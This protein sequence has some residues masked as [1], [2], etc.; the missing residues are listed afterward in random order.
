M[1]KGFMASDYP[2]FPTSVCF[3]SEDAGLQRV[4]DRC[5]ALARGNI[6]QFGC[7]KVLQEGAKYHGVWLETQPMGGEMYAKR[8]ME[9]ALNNILI[10]MECQ[11]RDGRMP[12]MITYNAPWNGLAVHMD[13]MQGDFF[14]IPALR[15]FYHIGRDMGYLRLLYQS[16]KDFDNYLWKYRDSDGDGCLESW[17]MWDTGDDNNT[18]YLINR[19]HARDNGAWNGETPPTGIG[20]LPLESA[21]YM[22]YSYAHR[23]ALAHISALL[24]NGE[25]DLWRRKAEDV[26]R[27]F[28]EYLW[29]EK[30]KFAFDRDGENKKID[31]ISLANIK[32]MYQGIFTQDM[33]DDFIRE[34][35]MNPEEFWTPT[36]LPNLAV[37]DP[38]FYL[39]AEHH[40]LGERMELVR[41]YL[42]GDAMDNSWSGPVQGLNMQRSLHALLRYGHHAEATMVGC[43][44]LKTLMRCDRFVQQYNPFTGSPAPGD[45]GYG[46]TLLS[47]LEYIAY[48]HGVN[49]EEEHPIWSAAQSPHAHEYAL[50]MYSANFRL[51]CTPQEALAERN[52]IE[53]FR[54]T[55]GVRIRTDGSGVPEAIFGMSSQA[56]PFRLTYQ[57][58]TFSAT[59]HP[60]EELHI[61]GNEL[62]SVRRVPFSMG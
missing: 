29:D 18:R 59:I 3:H 47:A 19:V 16:L 55:P 12:G 26:R 45:E 1:S 35:L 44:W 38:L 9:V 23:D 50:Q 6:Q 31:S 10:F 24:N 39:D 48:L 53:C 32:C 56:M 49:I 46:P 27:R 33:A 40:N 62:V 4:Y 54:F 28:R 42:A 22:A 43:R 61:S 52:G 15:M 57:G 51:R 7:R 13:W 2:Y 36:P 5:E 14:T 25:E 37:N 17:C 8:N 11:R 21:E 60:N 58:Q 20:G 34:H 41:Q 30:R